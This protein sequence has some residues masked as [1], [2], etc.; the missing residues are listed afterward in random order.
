MRDCLSCAVTGLRCPSTDKT[1]SR[2]FSLLQTV[3]VPI[4][5]AHHVGRRQLK[6]NLHGHHARPRATCRGRGS[7]VPTADTL[8]ADDARRE[9]RVQSIQN[10]RLQ[11]RARSTADHADEKINEEERAS[12]TD[13]CQPVS[14]SCALPTPH[15]PPNPPRC[16]GMILA[17]G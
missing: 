7:M 11:R 10:S 5:D 3:S 2:A 4:G 8:D 14:L 16:P 6:K 12:Q 17:G 15:W 1:K 13:P 9:V